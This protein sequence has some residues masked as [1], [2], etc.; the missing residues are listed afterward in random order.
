M[1]EVKVS[2]IT[3]VGMTKK[4]AEQRVFRHYSGHQGGLKK[5]SYADLIRKDSGRALKLAVLRMLN[6]NRLRAKLMKRLIVEK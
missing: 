6:K 5:I 3:K 2:N 4:K 1:I